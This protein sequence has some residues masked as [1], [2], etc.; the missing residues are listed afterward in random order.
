MSTMTTADR[1]VYLFI[2]DFFIEHMYAPT[3]REIMTGLGYSSTSTIHTRLGRLEEI[4]MIKKQQDSPR[5]M[6][7]KGLKVIIDEGE[8][9]VL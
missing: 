6:W 4:G 5:A 3:V 2:R 7:I 1:L 8:E 9:N